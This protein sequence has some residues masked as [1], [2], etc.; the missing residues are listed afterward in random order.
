M[1]RS[2]LARLRK[3]CLA[4][5][6]AHEVEAWGESTFRVKNRMFAT[7]AAANNH[8]GDGRAGVWIK[9]KP[10]NQQLLLRTGSGRYFSP[11]Y[12]GPRGWIGVYL[13]DSPDWAEIEELLRDAWRLTAPKRLAATLADT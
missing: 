5:P 10:I 8:H 13:D 2:P 3:L 9:S 4:L 7:Y 11:P 1:A 12:V 6:G